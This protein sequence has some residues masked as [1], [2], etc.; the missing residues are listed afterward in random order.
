MVRVQVERHSSLLGTKSAAILSIMLSHSCPF[1]QHSISQPV[2]GILFG[3][4]REKRRV[5]EYGRGSL[6]V[7]RA[8]PQLTDCLEQSKHKFCFLRRLAEN[9]KTQYGG[10]FSAIQREFFSFLHTN[11]IRVNQ[12]SKCIFLPLL[13]SSYGRLFFRHFN[14][15]DHEL[16]AR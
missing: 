1:L 9:L 12:L 6:A 15:L 2:P 4:Q 7:F 5:K 8:T 3:D 14:E 10:C 13:R 11:L 16:Q